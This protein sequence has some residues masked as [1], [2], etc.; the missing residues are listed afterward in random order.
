[1]EVPEKVI[2]MRVQGRLAIIT[3]NNPTKLN[4]LTQPAYAYLG[5]LMRRIAVMPE[6]AVTVIAGTGAFFSAG[7]DL[8]VVDTMEDGEDRDRVRN[9][10]LR[11]YT[12][13]T[14]EVTRAFYSHPKI[15]V[16][17]MNGPAIGISAALLG[18]ADF[19]YATPQSWILLPFTSLGLAVEGCA[20]V[21]LVQRLGVP[22]A[23]EAILLAKKIPCEKLVQCNFV[24]KVFSGSDP[25]DS[26][27]FFKLVLNDV[28][29]NFN[30]LSLKGLL[31]TKN[32]LR[33]PYNDILEAQNVREIMVA[34]DAFVEGSPQ[35]EFKKL[36]SG[37]KRHK[38]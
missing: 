15:L 35:A 31:R 9:Q 28:S 23:N 24:N 11:D 3:L 26:A 21:G 6:V 37:Q 17:A 10:A 7:A 20:S 19:V 18:F 1:M 14:M 8:S 5:A 34:L 32:L 27:G 13:T 22:I 25:K 16:A 30:D 4:A 12:S 29:D 36:A 33:A 2:Q 38:L